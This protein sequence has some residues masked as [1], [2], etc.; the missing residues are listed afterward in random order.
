M[1]DMPGMQEQSD[2]TE[3][4]VGKFL[5]DAELDAWLKMMQTRFPQVFKA[6]GKEILF[7]SD[8]GQHP[9]GTKLLTHFDGDP[10]KPMR[11]EVKGSRWMLEFGD[12]EPVYVVS[13]GGGLSQIPLTRAHEESGWKVVAE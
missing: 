3:N 6:G 7:G 9:M 2:P 8:A 1:F 10:N 12:K 13:M 5:G 4:D 11:C